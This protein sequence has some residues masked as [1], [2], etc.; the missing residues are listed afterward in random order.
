MLNFIGNQFKKPS[1]FWGRVIS[2]LMKKG[3]SKAY[4]L[5][6]DDL[7][8]K[9]GDKLLEIGYGHGIGI[10]QICTN[11]D[12]NVDGIDFSE[13]MYNEAKKRNA[14]HIKEGRVR[15][16]FGDYLDFNAEACLYDK[17]FCLNVIY[18]WEE[19]NPPFSKI[20]NELKDGGYFCFFMAHRDDLNR[21]KFTKD[22]I[23]NK[24]TIDEVIASLKKVGFSDISYKQ[25]NGYFV[26]CKK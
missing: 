19:L 6:V 22:D 11:Y 10:T 26:K 5:I 18:F 17:I 7:E 13:L 4:E 15:L 24:Y 1:G 3:N 2:F 8:I 14:K 9:S 23:F 20:R 25:Q 12:C 21:L 16:S